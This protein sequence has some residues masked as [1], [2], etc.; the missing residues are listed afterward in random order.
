LARDFS[1]SHYAFAILA[2]DWYAIAFDTPRL[3]SLLPAGCQYWPLLIA[4]HC[5]CRQLSPAAWYFAGHYMARLAAIDTPPSDTM[6]ARRPD[7]CF[8]SA[9]LLRASWYNDITPRHC[10]WSQ[11]IRRYTIA[12]FATP[13]RWPPLAIWSLLPAADTIL[14]TAADTAITP[15]LLLRLLATIYHRHRLRHSITITTNTSHRCHHHHVIIDT[16]FT[17]SFDCA[18]VISHRDSC[19]RPWHAATFIYHWGFHH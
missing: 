17:P 11:M 13:R 10:R 3:P 9:I 5:C 7:C 15:L 12:Y 14:I 6:A 1:T 16:D 19:Q 8:F 2:I 4:G 18:F